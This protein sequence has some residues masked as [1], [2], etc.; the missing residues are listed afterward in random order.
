MFAMF[1]NY[2]HSQLLK[3]ISF[4]PGTVVKFR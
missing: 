2:I 3:P 1:K 4:C